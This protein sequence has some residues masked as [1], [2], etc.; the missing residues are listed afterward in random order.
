M[1]VDQNLSFDMEGDEFDCGWFGCRNKVIHSIGVQGKVKWVSEENHPYTGVFKGGQHG[2]GRFTSGMPVDTKTP[3]LWPGISVKFM[4]DGIDSANAVIMYGIHG[5]NDLNFFANSWSN[6]VLPVM[7]PDAIPGGIAFKTSTEYIHNMGLSNFASF[8]EEGEAEK[9]VVF[10]WRI[11]FGQTGEFHSPSDT[12]DR[13]YTTYLREI[14]AGSHLFNIYAMDV[15]PELGGTEMLIGKLYSESEFV[16]SHWGDEHLFFRHQ[17]MDDDLKYHPEWEPYV[18]NVQFLGKTLPEK[19][20][21]LKKVGLE[22]VASQV[23]QI[24]SACPFAWVLESLM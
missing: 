12:Y 16:T 20:E 22:Y 10:P 19:M 2:I 3:T 23:D 24:V 9:D 14:P 18:A 4:R 13:P 7:T 21:S 8:D 11:R 6:H 1:L 17:R 15:P 5:Q